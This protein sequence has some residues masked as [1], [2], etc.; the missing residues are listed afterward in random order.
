M[1]KCLL[2]NIVTEFVDL[3]K[4]NQRVDRRSKAVIGP[5]PSLY[6][7]VDSAPWRDYISF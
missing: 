2:D 1:K 7:E 6:D 4:V 5:S 3:P